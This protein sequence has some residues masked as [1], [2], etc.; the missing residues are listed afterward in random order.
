LSDPNFK[1]KVH[2]TIFIFSLFDQSKDPREIFEIVL[3]DILNVVNIEGIGVIVHRVL[4]EV[5]V[6][7]FSPN[8]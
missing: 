1:R 3:V 8:D 7:L 2:L 6:V 4:V 5:V